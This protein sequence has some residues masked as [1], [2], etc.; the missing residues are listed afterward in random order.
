M[1][2][3][4]HF[5]APRPS[6][7]SLPTLPSPSRPSPSHL[8][9][10]K[11]SHF[12]DHLKQKQ[13]KT[14]QVSHQLDHQ[15]HSSETIPFP[16]SPYFF[17][18]V[19]SFLLLR[20]FL[21]P[22]PFSLHS[23]LFPNTSSSPYTLFPSAATLILLTFHSATHI[24]CLSSPE[25]ICHHIPLPLPFPSPSRS[26]P[27]YPTVPD[28]PSPGPP[29]TKSAQNVTDVPPIGPPGTV[30]VEDRGKR[31]KGN[32]TGMG[33]DKKRRRAYWNGDREWKTGTG[34]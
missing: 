11:M 29:E 33:A 14:S 16:I 23:R 9:R 19:P 4:S 3:S 27:S 8:H 22:S 31:R 28:V 18:L 20:S 15:E 5:P 12:L 10:H 32:S 24:P 21:H 1:L 26:S 30:Q 7:H 25:P 2:L 13:P 6:L 17:L 34:M